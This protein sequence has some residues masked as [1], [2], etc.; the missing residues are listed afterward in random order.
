MTASLAVPILLVL[1]QICRSCDILFNDKFVKDVYPCNKILIINTLFKNTFTK[2]QD[3]HLLHQ[4]V[5]SNKR[6][7]IFNEEMLRLTKELKY[8]L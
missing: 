3:K 1:K 8:S 4:G 5:L 7:D 2:L 6:L